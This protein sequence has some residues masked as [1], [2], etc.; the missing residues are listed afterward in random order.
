MNFAHSYNK[1]NV[2]LL[3]N[4]HHLF[5]FIA[6]SSNVLRKITLPIIVLLSIFTDRGKLPLIRVSW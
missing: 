6:P 5:L 4:W 1:S 2:A 3:T